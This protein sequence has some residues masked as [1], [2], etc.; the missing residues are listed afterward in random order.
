MWRHLTNTSNPD[1][2]L[3]DSYDDFILEQKLPSR[4][5]DDFILEQ[6]LPSRSASAQER[7]LNRPKIDSSACQKPDVES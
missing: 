6:K 5:Y 3:D 4:S 7:L 1:F 2:A